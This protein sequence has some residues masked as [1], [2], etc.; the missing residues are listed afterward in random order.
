MLRHRYGSRAVLRILAAK[1][2]FRTIANRRLLL[3]GVRSRHV[4]ARRMQLLIPTIM[5]R[6]GAGMACE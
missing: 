4:L 6:P 2:T 5:N 1:V 3:V